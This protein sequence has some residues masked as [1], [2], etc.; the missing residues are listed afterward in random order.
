MSWLLIL[1]PVVEIVAGF[2]VASQIGGGPTIAL[3]VVCSLVGASLLRR[4]VQRRPVRGLSW[5]AGTFLL[6]LPG[7]ATAAI[8]LLLLVPPLNPLTRALSGRLARRWLLRSRWA[9]LLPVH[10]PVAAPFEPRPA[11]ADTDAA[12]IEGEVIEGEVADGTESGDRPK[13]R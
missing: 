10:S 8:G 9:G 11:G 7:F 12:V 1:G 3:L 5:L 4:G 2:A 6:A 13:P